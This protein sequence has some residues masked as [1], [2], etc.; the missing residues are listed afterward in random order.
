MVFGATWALSSRRL[1]ASS[2]RWLKGLSG[3]ALLLLSLVLIFRP[4]WLSFS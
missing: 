4:A 1:S 2:G 3:A